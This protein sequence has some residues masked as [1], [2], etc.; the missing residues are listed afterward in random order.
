M[1]TFNHYL[2]QLKESQLGLIAIWITVSVALTLVFRLIRS[3]AQRQ[4][5][6]FAFLKKSTLLNDFQELAKKTKLIFLF[7]LAAYLSRSL[8][9]V[10]ST[11]FELIFD[12]IFI[13]VVGIQLIIW[14]GVWIE[15]LVN[16]FLLPKVSRGSE[17]AAA[18]LATLVC[19]TVLFAGI[20]LFT[21]DNLGINITALVTGLGVGGI[22]VALAVQNIL[23][24]LFSSLT[25]VLDK[26][27]Q[28][29]DSITAGEE[30][31]TVENIGLK[32][33]RVRSITGEELIFSN[34]DLLKSRIRNFKR[35]QK[36]RVSFKLA[37]VYETPLN[38]LEKIPGLIEGIIKNIETAELDRVHLKNLGDWAIEYEC[39]YWVKSSEYGIYMDTH[40]KVLFSILK[41]FEVEKIE[42]AF[43]TQTQLT[44]EIATKEAIHRTDSSIK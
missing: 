7:A 12:R 1:E 14:S 3:L 6:V 24:D 9:K 8:L 39:V 20:L 10:D 13:I 37:V 33:T 17:L 42:F 34:S 30:S 25:I 21:L 22:A 40:Q 16:R 26:P 18:H 29:G 5:G 31:G 11:R 4:I 44:R 32:T 41:K 43:P 2:D 28:I 27:F 38:V 15:I 36:R 23:G 35:M 19:R